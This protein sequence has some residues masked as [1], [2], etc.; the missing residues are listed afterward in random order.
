MRRWDVGQTKTHSRKWQNLVKRY[1]VHEENTR[2]VASIFEYI[3]VSIYNRLHQVFRKDIE[4]SFRGKWK[5][6]EVVIEE[7]YNSLL[8]RKEKLQ[9]DEIRCK[10]R[11][12]M[13][14]FCNVIRFS[15]GNLTDN[16]FP[17]LQSFEKSGG[18]KKQ[19]ILKYFKFSCK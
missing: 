9:P 5:Q 18:R 17:Q 19:K 12:S 14:H 15:T 6:T 16:I 11:F 3:S 4:A 8:G 7:A 13:G 1:H 10:S 2:Q